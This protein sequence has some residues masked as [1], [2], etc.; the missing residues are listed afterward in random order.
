MMCTG[1]IWCRIG[2]SGRLFGHG[3]ETFNVI[4]CGEFLD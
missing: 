3:N 2:A 1:L 4:K